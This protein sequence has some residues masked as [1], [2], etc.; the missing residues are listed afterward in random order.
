MQYEQ[1]PHRRK[2]PLTGEWVLVSPHRNNRPWLGAS[3]KAPEKI[4]KSYDETCPLCPGNAR[5]NDTHNPD[6]QQTFVFKN[7]FGAINDKPVTEQGPEQDDLFQAQAAQGECRVICYS[8]EHDKTLPELSSDEILAVVDCW[9]AQFIE[10]SKQYACVHIFENKGEIMGCSQPHPHGQIWAHGYHSTEVATANAN[11]LAYWQKHQSTL[12][13][14]YIQR[15]INDGERVIINNPHWLVV[16][17][18]WAAWPFETLLIA[19]DDVAHMGQLSD[20]QKACLANT[21]QELTIR[22]DN[23]FNCSF[24]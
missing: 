1:S 8:P 22:Y 14:D 18:F 24:P 13:G 23:I 16:V 9:Q 7:D 15:E 17:P 10:L 12:L 21:L 11:Q 2:N 6:Y 20:E 19:K 4:S 5:A 3:E